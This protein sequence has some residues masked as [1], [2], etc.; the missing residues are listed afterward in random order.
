[1]SFALGRGGGLAAN[2][3]GALFAWSP[4]ATSPA[5]L[6]NIDVQLK[7]RPTG[8]ALVEAVKG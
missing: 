5:G 4:R 7:R 2:S 1:V 6:Q 3:G 8:A